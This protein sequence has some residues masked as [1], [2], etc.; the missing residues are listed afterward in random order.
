MDSSFSVISACEAALAAHRL[1]RSAWRPLWP[2][3][4]R[5]WRLHLAPRRVLSYILCLSHLISTISCVCQPTRTRPRRR[6][7]PLQIQEPPCCLPAEVSPISSRP[8]EVV[9]R[10][11]PRPLAW[12][13]PRPFGRSRPPRDHLYTADCS[14]LTTPRPTGCREGYRADS[15]AGAGQTSPIGCPCRGRRLGSHTAEYMYH[16]A[17]AVAGCSC[18]K[19]KPL[20]W[21]ST[22]SATFV[23]PTSAATLGMDLCSPL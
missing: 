18:Q 12:F 2:R 20:R 13:G 14:R 19:K 17:F 7:R 6:R 15:I 1:P 8:R 3:C 23:A 21:L 22:T 5:L 10:C 4:F 16:P 9:G 11:D